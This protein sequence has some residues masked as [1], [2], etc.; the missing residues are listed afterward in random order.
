VQLPV[1]PL[2]NGPIQTEDP[3]AD[4]RLQAGGV[5]VDAGN[6]A[7]YLDDDYHHVRAGAA[8]DVGA[9]ELGEEWEMA[10]GPRWAVGAKQPWRPT[11]PPSLDPSWL[12]IQPVP[13]PG[14]VAGTLAGLVVL[15]LMKRRR[16]GRG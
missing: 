5:S 6:P 11:P 14:S 4:F 8:P 12:G 16:E 2:Q 3:M 7:L 13:E 1:L 9:I 15:A 10:T